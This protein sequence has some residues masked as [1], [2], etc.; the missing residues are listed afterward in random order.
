MSGILFPRYRLKPRQHLSHSPKLLQPL[1][2]RQLRLQFPLSGILIVQ[3]VTQGM[4]YMEVKQDT[5]CFKFVPEKLS[6]PL[7]TSGV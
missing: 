4:T 1:R 2:L 3:V 5:S 6:M 7:K